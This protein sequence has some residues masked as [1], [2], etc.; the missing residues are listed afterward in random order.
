MPAFL[1]RSITID[2]I[3]I[4]SLVLCVAIQS[5]LAQT[6]LNTLNAPNAFNAPTNPSTLNLPTLGDPASQVLSLQ[7]EADIGLSIW[8]S[9]WRDDELLEDPWLMAYVDQIGQKLASVAAIANTGADKQAIKTQ[10]I[11]NVVDDASL[12]FFWIAQPAIN[13]FA[14][15]GGYIGVHTGLLANTQTE[16]EFASVLSHEI[17]HVTQRHIA[18]MLARQQQFTP[19]AIASV[20]L[21]IIVAS[22]NPSAAAGIATAGSGINAQGYLNFSR[23]AEREADRLGLQLLQDSGFSAQGMPDFFGRLISA[24]RLYENNAPAYLRTHPLTSER[25]AD[26]LGRVQQ[27]RYRQHVSSITFLLAKQRA[28]LQGKTNAQLNDEGLKASQFIQPSQSSSRTSTDWRERLT[29]Y[30]RLALIAERREQWSEAEQYFNRAQQTLQSS[31]DKQTPAIRHV[32]LDANAALMVVK[33]NNPARTPEA[34][35]T[36]R[37]LAQQNPDQAVLTWVLVEALHEQGQF[38]QVVQLL[39]QNPSVAQFSLRYYQ[40]LA[41]SYFGL[42]QI[43]QQHW[44][45]VN[46][47]ETLG[48]PSLA[49]EQIRL[50]RQSVQGND[51]FALLSQLD[52]KESELKAQI[53]KLKRP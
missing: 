24:T 43:A 33:Q 12:R 32:W 26:M 45:L 34:L 25:M 22:K 9:L 13:A 28:M 50:S 19:L 11:A 1:G 41:S 46:Y 3:T 10:R 5:A 44:M 42:G 8:Q 53:I 2:R 7:Q 29:A 30:Y 47:Y 21:A 16:S 36:L 37:Q 38:M 15:P 14:L 27:L 17:A 39:T 31:A 6:G 49:L 52:S 4:G 18:R 23:D 20:L 35:A 51:Q 48:L 40:R